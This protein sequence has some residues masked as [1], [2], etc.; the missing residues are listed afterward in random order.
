MSILERTI[1]KNKKLC[2]ET[3]SEQEKNIPND[4]CKRLGLINEDFSQLLWL[5][6]INEILKS[7]E[8][9]HRHGRSNE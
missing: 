2:W 1:T 6:V 7:F 5:L 3:M 9:E 4:Q 8:D